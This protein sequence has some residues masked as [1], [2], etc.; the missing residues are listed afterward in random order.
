MRI[1]FKIAEGIWMA[2]FALSMVFHD[3]APGA[4]CIGAAI[5]SRMLAD[6]EPK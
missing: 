1:V 3:Y 4:A 6:K 2:G 5:Y